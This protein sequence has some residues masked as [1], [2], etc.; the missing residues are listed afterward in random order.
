L[1]FVHSGA[2]IVGREREIEHIAQQ[3]EEHRVRQYCRRG[4]NG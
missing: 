4:R 2:A 3:L 1:R